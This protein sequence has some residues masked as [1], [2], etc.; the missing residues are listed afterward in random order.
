MGWQASWI[1]FDGHSKAE[2]FRELGV[3]ETGKEGQPPDI[4]EWS[5][6]DLPDGRILI[7]HSWWGLADKAQVEKLSADREILACQFQDQGEPSAVLCAAREGQLLWKVTTVG[8][9]VSVEG[10][11]P[12]EFEPIRRE[13]AEQIGDDPDVAIMYEVC[14]DLGEALC[15]FSAE[16]DFPPLKALRPV[17]GSM[18]ESKSFRYDPEPKPKAT[19]AAKPKGCLDHLAKAVWV[20]FMVTAVAGI[21]IKLVFG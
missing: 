15:G 17:A 16:K 1:V 20:L 12:P 14:H 13:Y 2:L 4:G 11:P 10:A 18:L 6:L 8:D 19:A 9:D 3:E 5:Y 7:F 21:L